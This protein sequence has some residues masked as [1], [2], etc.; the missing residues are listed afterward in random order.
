[1]ALWYSIQ[2]NEM[3]IGPEDRT[4]QYFTWYEWTPPNTAQESPSQGKAI[5]T[6]GE[7]V[8]VVVGLPSNCSYL[9]AGC[10]SLNTNLVSTGNVT[11]MNG[12]FEGSTI[13]SLNLSNWN[14]SNVT[15]KHKFCS[16]FT[17]YV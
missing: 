5:H 3:W 11:N 15:N 13:T 7:F 8:S 12:M 6:V 2:G 10:T 1:M 9:F 17:E 14:V 4:S 16:L